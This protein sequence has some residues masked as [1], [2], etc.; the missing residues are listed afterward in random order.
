MQTVER[1]PYSIKSSENEPGTIFL[2]QRYSVQDGPGIRTTVFM[3][4]CPLRCR[5]CQNP[6]S[7]EPHPELMSRDTKCIMCGRCAEACPIGV[8]SFDLEKGRKIDR[9]GCNLCFECI[10]ACPAK[11]LI[12]VGRT[13]T[14]EEVMSEVE[15]DEI[16]YYRSGGGVT[17]SGGEPLFQETFVLKLLMACKDRGLHTALDTCG[18]VRRPVFER[19]L[20]HVDLVLFDVKHMNPKHHRETTGTSNILILNNIRRIPPDKKIWLRIPLIPGYNDSRDNLRKLRELALEIRA[21]KVSILPFH[22]LGESKI[23]QIGKRH[24][25]PQLKPPDKEHLQEIKE[26]I[27]HIGVKVTIGE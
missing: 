24:N 13:M 16:I 5:W 3:K 14:V 8:I 9:T 23:A 7:W 22:R 20:E 6:E 12:R 17:V 25:G 1:K 27:E 26:F 15:R 19:M 10:E 21:E 4:G 18:Y 2:I 11:A